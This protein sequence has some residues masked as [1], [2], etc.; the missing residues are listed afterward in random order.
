MKLSLN[1]TLSAQPKPGH[2]EVHPIL[3]SMNDQPPVPSKITPNG[4]GGL[5][6]A[7]FTEMEI[8]SAKKALIEKGT[9]VLEGVDVDESYV[10]RFFADA[11]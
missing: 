6:N 1:I 7:G 2:N 5:V 11:A 9:T 4:L 3:I 10:R 8:D